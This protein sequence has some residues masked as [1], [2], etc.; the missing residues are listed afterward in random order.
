MA[1]GGGPAHSVVSPV[2]GVLSQT[3]GVHLVA[4]GDA[5]HQAGIHLH[6]RPVSQRGEALFQGFHALVSF[7]FSGG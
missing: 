1:S 3:K 4:S 6:H 2:P 5:H 7:R